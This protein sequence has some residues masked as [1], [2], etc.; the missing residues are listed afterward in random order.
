MKKVIK[1]INKYHLLFFLFFIL[2]IVSIPFL[3]KLGEK[4]KKGDYLVCY[5][6]DGDTIYACKDEEKLLVRLIGIDAPEM[7][8]Q[9][10]VEAREY[11]DN[12]L[13]DKYVSLQYDQEKND[14][15]GREL[16]YVWL[17][18]V[19]INAEIVRNGYAIPM[20]IEPNTYYQKE[21]ALAYKQ[22]KK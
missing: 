8:S 11:V 15:Y 7:D 12:L 22:A 2:L 20:T 13:A 16:C 10:G 14:K 9:E 1:F 19:L 18:D 21:I 6:V 3:M 5:V 4:E 17:D